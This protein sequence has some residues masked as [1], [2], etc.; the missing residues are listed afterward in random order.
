ML[1]TRLVDHEEA[2]RAYKSAISRLPR[3]PSTARSEPA[4]DPGHV[5]Q[6]EPPPTP[7]TSETPEASSMPTGFGFEVA[8][9]GGKPES[10]MTAFY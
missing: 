6:V 4:G 5:P 1:G 8:T 3:S 7:T 2:E 10:R 9:S